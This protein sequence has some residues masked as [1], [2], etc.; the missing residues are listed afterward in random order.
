MSIAWI[1]NE[2]LPCKKCDLYFVSTIITEGIMGHL[3]VLSHYLH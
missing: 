1:T 3:P 2:I